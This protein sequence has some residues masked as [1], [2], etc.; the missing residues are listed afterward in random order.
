MCG[1][2]WNAFFFRAVQVSKI[3]ESAVSG[4]AVHRKATVLCGRILAK[5]ADLLLADGWGW[6]VLK[7]P[8]A[9][10]LFV[11]YR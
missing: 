6:W 5:A 10:G 11:K 9:K 2:G 4:C 7:E 3:K 8:T 1:W